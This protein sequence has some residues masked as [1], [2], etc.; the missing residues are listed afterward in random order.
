MGRLPGR[1][2]DQDLAFRL[3]ESGAELR[4]GRGQQRRG[5][6]R[7]ERQPD[8]GGGQHLLGELAERLAELR[9]EGESAHL[10]EHADHRTGEFPC[11]LRQLRGPH[12][13]DLFGHRITQPLPGRQGLLEPIVG[14]PGRRSGG[15]RGKCGRAVQPQFGQARGIADGL[16]RIFRH[17]R[18]IRAELLAGQAFGHVVVDRAGLCRTRLS[19]PTE[20]L[21]E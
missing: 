17:R 12:T 6:G 5:T 21:T 7:A 18:H 13:G 16:G 1:E 8:I 10:P 9:A 15:A 4:D 3:L 20:H 19:H 11:L 2:E 14:G